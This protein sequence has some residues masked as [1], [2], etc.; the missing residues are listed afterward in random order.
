MT[1]VIIELGPG[2]VR[3]RNDAPPEL[4]SAALECIDDDIA[5]FDERP[6]A[7]RDLWA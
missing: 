4:I 5:L 1:E 2:T 6:V 3:G 7:V